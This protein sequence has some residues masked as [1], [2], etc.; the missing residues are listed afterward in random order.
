[1]KTWLLS[2][3]FATHSLFG[4]ITLV[5]SGASGPYQLN[6]SQT[7]SQNF[8]SLAST[9]TIHSFSNNVS[10]SGWYST[11]SFYSINA[12]GGLGSYGNFNSSDRA[13]G[14]ASG[15]RWAVCFV[16]NTSKTIN[17]FEL[18]Y[19]GEQWR[20]GANSPQFID[21]LV[22]D[23]E[24]YPAG[25]GSYTSN[26]WTNAPSLGYSSPNHTDTTSALLDGNLAENQL[27]ITG[28]VLGLSLA[29]GQEIWL[30]WR[31]SDD[32]SRNDHALAIDDL[33]VRFITATIP[34]PSSLVALTGFGALALAALRR[35]V[36][37]TS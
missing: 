26:N 22:F 31:V 3:L 5:D 6:V 15:I 37:R 7:Y 27:A 19:T 28:S 20:R 8:D 30:R 24:L 4:Q 29:P 11:D 1:M 2:L 10:L 33:S 34:E 21:S 9:G 36:R 32:L 12:S 18:S 16:N 23:Y 13:I 17:G 14:S 35:P 25:T